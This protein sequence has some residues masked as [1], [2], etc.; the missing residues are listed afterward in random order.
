MGRQI[1]IIAS[2]VD[3]RMLL[4]YLRET[5][6]VWLFAR[7]APSEAELWMDAFPPFNPIQSQFYIWNT[8]YAWRPRITKHGGWCSVDLP[9]HGPVIEFQRTDIRA[10]LESAPNPSWIGHGRIYWAQ[11][12]RQKGFLRWYDGLTRWVR[13]HGHNVSPVR[14]SAWYCLPDA[15]KLWQERLAS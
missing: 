5:A 11:Y 12:N 10:V 9:G 1:A 13:R 6:E 14:T 3:E 7:T 2:E 8:A 4:A 15:Y